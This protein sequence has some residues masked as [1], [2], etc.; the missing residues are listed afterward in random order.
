MLAVNFQLLTKLLIWC[1]LYSVYLEYLGF[2]VAFQF[3]SMSSTTL[4]CYCDKRLLVFV[5]I[6]NYRITSIG[7]S[8]FCACAL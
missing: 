7:I 6:P 5:F 8:C 1:L 2:F 3:P 4:Q